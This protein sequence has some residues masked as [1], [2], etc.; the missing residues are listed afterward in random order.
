M[1][2]LITGG[3]G[4][5]GKSLVAALVEQ[6]HEA[7]IFSRSARA[8]DR[9]KVRFARFDPSNDESKSEAQ[10]S[11]EKADVIVNLAGENIGGRRWSA[12][13]K[14]R[15][16]SSR[17]DTTRALVEMVDKARQ[18]PKVLISASAVG[19]YG[20]HGAE[21]LDEST[22]PGNDF[23]AEVC[24][25]WEAEA[26]KA[27][28]HGVR[29]VLLRTGVVFGRGGA[30]KKMLAPFKLFV[31]GPLGGGKQGVSWI[32]IDDLIRGILFV[33]EKEEIK[34]AVNAV[35]PKPV[36]NKELSKT[37]GRMLKR[38]A[39][40]PV[41]GVVL[42]LLLSEQATIVLDGQM[43]LPKKLQEAGFEF[44]YNELEKALRE[45]VQ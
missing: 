36:S 35:S 31:G 26:L 20:P 2:F 42:K 10:E 6:N 19:Y 27:E 28:E 14:R 45:I 13:Q 11:V 22:P 17:I 16:L 33:L 18:K 3:T 21:K 29:V 24:E 38:P 5:I 4:F 39:F 41:P 7:I 8:S 9:P 23:L 12:A 15:I 44:E 25:T 30:L 32:H 37:I 34:G 43:V 40:W 1:K